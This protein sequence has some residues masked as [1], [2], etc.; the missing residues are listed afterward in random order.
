MSYG[1]VWFAEL[2]WATDEAMYFGGIRGSVR[3][4]D[5]GYWLYFGCYEAGYVCDGIMFYPFGDWIFNWIRCSA[6]D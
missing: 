1:A 4:G 6:F 3:F 5:V 2:A